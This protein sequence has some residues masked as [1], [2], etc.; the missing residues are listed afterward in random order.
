LAL[1]ATQ[2]ADASGR[3]SPIPAA[4]AA[5]ASLARMML[6]GRGARQCLA[7]RASLT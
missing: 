3:L 1:L 4:T 5:A 7:I 6:A 2:L